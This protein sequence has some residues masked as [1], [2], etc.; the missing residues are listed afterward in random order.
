MQKGASGIFPAAANGFLNRAEN[1]K[2]NL[3]ISEVG[4]YSKRVTVE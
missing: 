3:M 1:M 2:M 4:S